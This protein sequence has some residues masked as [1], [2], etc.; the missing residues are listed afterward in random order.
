MKKYYTVADLNFC[1]E[2]DTKHYALMNNYTNFE[3]DPKSDILFSITIK[4]GSYNGTYHIETKQEDE[5]QEIICGINNESES[6]FVYNNHNQHV[7]TMVCNNTYTIATL[8]ITESYDEKLAID[9][10]MMIL[11]ALSSAKY[12]AMLF[13][14]SV[15]SLR[16]KAYMFLGKSGTG[17]STHSR[18]W[19][20]NIEGTALVNDDNP[21]VRIYNDIVKVYGSPWSGKTPC[22]N[23]IEYTLGAL[24]LL[25]QAKENKITQLKGI[26]AYAA[27]HPAISGK[28]WDKSIADNLH[29]SENTLIQ[30]V[31][32][33]HLECLPNKEAAVLCQSTIE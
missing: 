5:G 23:S 11:Y 15:V 31:D 30:K 6:V 33:Y 32:V 21:I 12:S 29:N 17:K 22:Y 14:A 7:G 4:Q 25:S 18:L 19:L 13:H 8:Y 10:S 1:V 28:R 9:N 27:I 26:H 24:V 3:T 2:A 16:S 20:N